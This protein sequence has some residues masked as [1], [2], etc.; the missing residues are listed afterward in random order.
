MKTRT[1]PTTAA[2]SARIAAMQRQ[3]F[4]APNIIRTLHLTT[5]QVAQFHLSP[6]S[7]QPC[8]HPLTAIAGDDREGTHYCA[9]CADVPA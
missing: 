2:L 3:G 8:G 9:A 1:A 5:A 7:Q 6:A 4:T